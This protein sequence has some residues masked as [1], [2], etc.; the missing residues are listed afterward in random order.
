M[1][2]RSQFYSLWQLLP[3]VVRKNNSTGDPRDLHTT[4]STRKNATKDPVL[5]PS[6][7]W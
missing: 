6:P 1:I 3:S 7:R 4:E 2:G 5:E